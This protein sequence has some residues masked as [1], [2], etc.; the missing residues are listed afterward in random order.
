VYVPRKNS[1]P[2]KRHSLQKTTPDTTMTPFQRLNSFMPFIILTYLT[3]CLA[4]YHAR[5]WAHLSLGP[6]GTISF[7]KDFEN[8][9]VQ[10]EKDTPLPMRDPTR[11]TIGDFVPP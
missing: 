1:G 8:R 11:Y 6:V 3:M 4:Q 9:I 7:V 5:P 2:R 10:A